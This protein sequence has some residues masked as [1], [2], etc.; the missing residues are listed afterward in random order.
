MEVFFRDF[1]PRLGEKTIQENPFD[2]PGFCAVKLQEGCPGSQV[3]PVVHL[4]MLINVLTLKRSYR[5]SFFR[6]NW[7]EK[8]Q[9]SLLSSVIKVLASL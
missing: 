8:V 5:E 9:T 4:Q 3:L 1:F 7:S 6:V 2:E